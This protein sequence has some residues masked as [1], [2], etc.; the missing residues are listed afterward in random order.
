MSWLAKNL[1]VEPVEPDTLNLHI[2]YTKMATVAEALKL[3]F[4]DE[5]N[6]TKLNL[7]DYTY[8][9]MLSIRWIPYPIEDD[10]GWFKMTTQEICI[11][12]HN[13]K[14]LELTYI[15]SHKELDYKQLQDFIDS[16]VKKDIEE[17]RNSGEDIDTDYMRAWLGGNLVNHSV[18]PLHV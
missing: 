6:P 16:I 5:P 10:P 8:G 4:V 15:W 3:A 17:V 9:M 13:E 2:P 18:F 14:I 7:K 1:I 11:Y 12:H